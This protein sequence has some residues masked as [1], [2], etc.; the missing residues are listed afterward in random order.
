MRCT[1]FLSR[2]LPDSADLAALGRLDPDRDWRELVRGE[3]AWILQ[4]F[5][6]LRRAGF[7][8][9]LA[10]APPTDGLVVFHAKEARA[11]ARLRPAPGVAL[12]GVRADN[13]QPLIA[14]FEVLQNGHFADGRRRF[15]VPHW[16]QPGLLPRDPA[17]GD[18][19]ER[20]AYK[21]Y[22]QNLHPGL[23]SAEWTGFLAER[24]LAWVADA[25]PFAGLSTERDALDWP[26]F[27]DVDLLVALRP[28]D[29]RLWTSKPAT[30]LVNAWLAGVPAILGPEVAY[31]ELR[32][33]PLD[34]LEAAT[35]AEARAAVLRLAT[36]PALYRA[37]VEHGRQRMAELG[38][39]GEL[40][41]LGREAIVACWSR[42]LGEEIPARAAGARRDGAGL[43]LRSFPLPLRAAL[44]RAGRV[45]AGRPAR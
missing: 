26:D 40:G 35:V 29:R 30:K 12:V 24:G 39:L 28:P 27:R 37:M 2:S 8:A 5:L 9:E 23:R 6:F 10:A 3:R 13:R 17:R 20:L 45:L 31:R 14:D 32:R 7:P 15:A 4:T 42:L 16:P 11:L 43:P 44:R 36:D 38:E 21:G 19:V 33:S 25:V 34:Y 41:D 18:R 1:F 22:A